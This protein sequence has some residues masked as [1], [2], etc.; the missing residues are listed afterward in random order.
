MPENVVECPECGTD[1]IDPVFDGGLY[2][3]KCD[4]YYIIQENENRELW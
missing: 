3:R 4:D 1:E 2:C